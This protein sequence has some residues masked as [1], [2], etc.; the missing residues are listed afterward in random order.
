[1]YHVYTPWKHLKPKGFLT[2]PGNIEMG[3]WAKIV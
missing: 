1:M 2:F 3:H